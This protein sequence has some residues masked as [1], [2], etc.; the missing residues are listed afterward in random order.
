MTDK[1]VQKLSRKELLEI[2][3]EQS[4]ELEKLQEDLKQAEERNRDREIKIANAGSIAEAALSLNS[5]FEAAQAAADQYLVNLQSSEKM[6]A[7]VKQE[8]EAEAAKT[9]EDAKNQASTIIADARVSA[10]KYWQEVTS[11]L[12][13]FYDDYIGLRDAVAACGGI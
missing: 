5:I 13:R 3:I 2:L 11:R 4:E 12:E 9:I 8:A 10:E 1:E 7:A 6:A